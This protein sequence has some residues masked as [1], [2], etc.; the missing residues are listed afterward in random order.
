M[1]NSFV[2]SLSSLMPQTGIIIET[3]NDHI[4]GICELNVLLVE[5]EELWGK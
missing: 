1:Y 5:K 3:I 2:Y 4:E